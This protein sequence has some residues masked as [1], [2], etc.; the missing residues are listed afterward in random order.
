[1]NYRVTNSY[2]DANLTGLLDYVNTTYAT[3]YKIF[4]KPISGSSDGKT[5]SE[6]I[7][8]FD[9]GEVATIY[10]YKTG[11]TPT[12]EYDW[13]IGGNNRVVVNRIRQLVNG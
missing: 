6:W 1:M 13:H 9:D 10:N 8:R 4:G 12:E 2:K 3:L 11:M 5:N 7:I